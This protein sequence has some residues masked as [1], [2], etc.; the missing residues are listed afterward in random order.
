VVEE[1]QP[2][3][4]PVER[5][6]ADVLIGDESHIAASG[7]SSAIASWDC[8][9]AN[10]GKQCGRLSSLESDAKRCAISSTVGLLMR[11][12]AS[13]KAAWSISSGNSPNAIAES[14]ERKQPRR[15]LAPAAHQC[16]RRGQKKIVKQ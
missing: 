3:P 11:S 9:A 12:S 2:P 8:D 4:A 13:K 7:G 10:R 6:A 16:H 5:S 15:N 1:E 14:D